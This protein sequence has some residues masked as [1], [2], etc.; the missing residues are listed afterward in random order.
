[1]LLLFPLIKYLE[2]NTFCCHQGELLRS[3]KS[4]KN[5]IKKKKKKE[6]RKKKKR[7]SSERDLQTSKQPEAYLWLQLSQ[8]SQG[9]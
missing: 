8:G 6:R 1:M 3:F 7:P 9:S 5:I 2:K 4:E